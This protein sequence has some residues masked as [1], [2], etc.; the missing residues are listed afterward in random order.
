MKFFF[1]ESGS[2]RIPDHKEHA[3]GIVVGI[4]VPELQADDFSRRMEK[5]IAG[6]PSSAFKRGEP[7][8]NFLD[9]ADRR[10]FAEMMAAMEGVLVCPTMLDLTSMVGRGME[11]RDKMARRCH[12]I[13]AQCH[14]ATMRDQMALLGRQVNN[15]SPEEICRLGC[16][17]QC[18]K[19]SVEDCIIRYAGPDFHG[20]WTKM[21]FDVDPVQPKSG[22]REEQIFSTMLPAWLTG[23]SAT[24]PFTL[25][26]EI[27]TE[28]HPL[29]RQWDNG[30]GIDLGKMFR[31]NVRFARS[32]ESRG[33][34]AADM[35]AFIARKAVA[36]IVNITDLESYAMMM[37]NA[38]RSDSDT[39]GLF[40]FSETNQ[41]DISRRYF[42]LVDAVSQ[43]RARS[44]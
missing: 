5:F 11:C 17:A 2:F 40:S 18:I 28:E 29:I 36:E 19:R 15:S 30:T 6:L 7:K 33:I 27:H 10:K 37:V 20:C 26:E 9:G 44:T 16:W 43:A 13:A 42:G 14:H 3:V 41:E 22:S 12:S 38:L 32:R 1:D 35:A 23:W 4:V 8:G 39:H 31:G 34:Q 25:I 21:T 24:R